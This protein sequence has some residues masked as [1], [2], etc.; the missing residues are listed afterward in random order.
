MQTFRAK[1]HTEPDRAFGLHG[2]A[3][4]HVVIHLSLSQMKLGFSRL[5][6]RVIG[7]NN[8]L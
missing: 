2:R 1:A 8:C 3:Q 5:R 6:R 7:M 4:S